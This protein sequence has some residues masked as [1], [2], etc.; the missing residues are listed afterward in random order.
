M[1]Q[2]QILRHPPTPPLKDH[3][4]IITHLTAYDSTFANLT[5]EETEL[6]HRYVIVNSL[7]SYLK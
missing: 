4:E 7:Y 1:L 5:K 6:V 2:L 3:P